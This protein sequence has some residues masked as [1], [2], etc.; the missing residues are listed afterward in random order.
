MA[1][2]KGN[3]L[4]SFSK[5][6]VNPERPYSSNNSQYRDPSRLRDKKE[7]GWAENPRAKG[8]WN[9]GKEKEE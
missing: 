4:A 2:E 1:N 7:Y 5:I 8:Y 3:E 6:K 9:T